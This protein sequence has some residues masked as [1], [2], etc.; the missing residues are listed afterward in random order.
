MDTFEQMFRSDDMYSNGIINET[1]YKQKKQAL[2]VAMS[3]RLQ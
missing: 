3:N 2:L 1:E